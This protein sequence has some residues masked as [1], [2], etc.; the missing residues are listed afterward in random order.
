[1]IL[2]AKHQIL[3]PSDVIENYD[4]GLFDLSRREQKLWALRVANT[5]PAL[6]GAAGNVIEIIAGKLY[7][8]DLKPHLEELG[9]KVFTPLAGL[10][11][12]QQQAW[13]KKAI[14][15]YHIS[16][17]SASQKSA[18]VLM[19]LPLVADPL[20]D[21][22]QQDARRLIVKHPNFDWRYGGSWASGA[23]W[24]FTGDDRA[25]AIVRGSGEVEITIYRSKENNDDP[26]IQKSD[27]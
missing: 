13:L 15:G 8:R 19:H 17:L 10:G 20:H 24:W 26:P 6:A 25:K 3:R 9:Y 22:L 4:I 14:D 11:I 23:T 12:G 27:N 7:W 1:M 21:T 2:S 5:L 18:D 16:A